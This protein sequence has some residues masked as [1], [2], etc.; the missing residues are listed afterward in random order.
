MWL[1]CATK[2]IF[3][4]EIRIGLKAEWPSKEELPLDF[5]GKYASAVH[6]ALC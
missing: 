3:E 6:L 5:A 2:E 1:R 4:V